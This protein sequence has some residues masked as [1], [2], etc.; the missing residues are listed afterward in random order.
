ML[1]RV[2]QKNLKLISIAASLIA[3]VGLSGCAGEHS[4][5]DCNEV[6]GIQSCVTLGHVN[7][8]A[9]QGDFNRNAG[10]NSANNS[11]DTQLTASNA[12][13][14]GM[15]LKTPTAGE[16]MRFGETIQDVWIAPYQTPDGEYV[17]PSMVTIIL[18]KGHWIGDPINAIQK[19]GEV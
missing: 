1:E 15:F 18:H 6:G 4:N 11:K 10:T 19:S 2:M 12:N 9:N 13:P 14:Q 5:F 3:V 16:P 8:M 7:R 17:W